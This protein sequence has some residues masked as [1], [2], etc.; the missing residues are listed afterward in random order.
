[1]KPDLKNS[2]GTQ[3]RFATA[4]M[5]ASLSPALTADPFA[6]NLTAAKRPE[7]RLADITCDVTATALELTQ[8]K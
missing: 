8:A 7:T 6:S 4:A 1:M 2:V 3:I 5:L